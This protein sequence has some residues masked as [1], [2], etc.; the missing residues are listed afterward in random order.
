MYTVDFPDDGLAREWHLT[1]TGVE[2]RT[3]AYHPRW[4]VTPASDL[5]GSF[6]DLRGWLT[7][8][9]AVVDTSTERWRTGYRESE[10]EVLRIDTRTPDAVDR[11]ARQVAQQGRP[12]Q[13]RCFDVDFD[14]QFRYCLE[15]GTDPTPDR[16]PTTLELSAP[17]RV[18]TGDDPLDETTVADE[19]LTGTPA[20]V[21]RRVASR[22]H[23]ADP[24]VLVCSSA[25]LLPTLFAA[26]DRPLSAYELGRRPGYE[27]VASASTYESYGQV[28]HSP[29]RYTLPGRAIVD[30]R[31][32]FLLHETNLAG[33]LDLVARSGRPLQELAWAS[34]GTVLTAIQIREAHDRGVLTPW[35]SWRPELFKSARTLHDADRGGFT[36]APA[37][38]VHEDVHELDFAS[39]YPNIIRTRNISPETI[40]CGCHD[41]DDVPGLGYAI[42]DDPGVLPDVLAPIID[43]REAI[44]ADLRET[45]DPETRE[46][47]EGRS[48]ALKWILVSCFGYQGF[49]NAKYGR[50]ECH[51]AIN[52]YARELILTAKDRFEAHGWRVLHGIVDSLWITAMPDREQTDLE[53][54]AAEISDRADVRLDYEGRFDW[55]AFVPQRESEAGALTKYF[56]RR[57]DADP[58]AAGLD[59]YKL[60]GIEARQRST[61]DWVVDVQ[62]DLL[63][64]FDRTRSPAA[65][66]DRLRRRLG[67][68]ERGDV[69]TDDLVI[70]QRVSK[71][72]EA[73]T[74]RTRTVAALERAAAAWNLQPGQYV[75]YVVVNDEAR[76]QARVA[77]PG[78]ADRYDAAFYTE[79]AVRATSSIL[80]PLGW[81]RD[82]VR[83]AL[84]ETTQ[85]SVE[86]YGCGSSDPS[87]ST[88]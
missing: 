36:F 50:I 62:T 16:A 51:E 73:Y 78:A 74:H 18:T 19:T 79:L 32:T 14:P 2:S 45:D 61:P 65:V 25:E 33:C 82:D 34:I 54:V 26:S 31:N 85:V 80:A 38:G 21:A 22:V 52:A 86:S 71:P 49:A 87:A 84:A 13:Y 15:T 60:R 20:D 1:E 28:G 48:A 76:G 57:A 37:V 44:K 63:R 39:L 55:C 41:R 8:H 75:E 53:T 5:D 47:L 88:R 27:Q 40:R 23:E 7:G 67:E 30:R 59:A 6:A 83:A 11:L 72:P 77:L 81:G 3:R 68:L 46:R 69:P 56:G 17:R 24:D 66:C 35:R 58:E 43:D 9:P 42:C 4:Y 10:R 70:D 64:V 29:A 12:G